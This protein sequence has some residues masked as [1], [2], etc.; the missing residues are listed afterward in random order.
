MRTL[1]SIK[2]RLGENDITLE[3]AAMFIP[4]S[5]ISDVALMI[6]CETP[7]SEEILECAKQAGL[8]PETYVYECARLVLALLDKRLVQGVNGNI[9]WRK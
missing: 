6:D 1:T 3:G 4:P 8:A 9:R 5:Y 2:R 7:K